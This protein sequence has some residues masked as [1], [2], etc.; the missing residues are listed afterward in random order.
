MGA[1]ISKGVA[2]AAGQAVKGLK[3][4]GKTIVKG[5]KNV[6]NKITKGVKRVKAKV[7]GFGKQGEGSLFKEGDSVSLGRTVNTQGRVGRE[8]IKK[9]KGIGAKN[10]QRAT[11]V[12]S[13]ILMNAPL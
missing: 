5:L 1:S 3:G 12:Y 9:G 8:V 13:D 10:Y 7:T 2:S 11:D 4:T 6:G